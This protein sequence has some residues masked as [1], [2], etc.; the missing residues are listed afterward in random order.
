MY[1]TKFHQAVILD[2]VILQKEIKSLEDAG[3]EVNSRLYVSR[4]ANL[5]LPGHRLLDAINEKKEDAKVGSTLKGIGPTYM[6]KTGRFGLRIGDY[7]SK[8]FEKYYKIATDRHRRLLSALGFDD[9]IDD[10]AWREAAEGFRKLQITDSELFINEALKNN[11]KILA[12][13]AQ[14]TLLDIDFGS[15]PYVTSSNTIAA[16]ACTGLGISPK[17][18]GKVYGIFK[19]Y[20]TRVGE[21]P[22][23]TELNDSV[24]QHL[25]DK[26]HEYGSTTGRP[27]RTGWLDLPALQ[28]SVM[29]NGVDEL[30]MM[31]IDVMNEMEEVK[32]CNAYRNEEGQTADFAGLAF[33]EA[34]HP[35]YDAFNGWQQDISS[36]RSYDAL[37][38]SMKTYIKYIEDKTEVPI[39]LISV[40]PERNETILK[41]V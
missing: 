33:R 23:P 11:K 4:K 24:G 15:Y 14:G 25:R 2:P 26:G 5:I 28:Y 32:I 10:T 38:E 41:A 20:C 21:G 3:I 30:F 37:P 29:L 34:I 6:D 27:R 9:T 8:D 1:C 36:I 17:K 16:A 18:L 39:S 35:E 22:F 13:G 7:L 31:K 40:G 19:A 12:E